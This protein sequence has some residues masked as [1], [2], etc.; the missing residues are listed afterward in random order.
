MQPA[1]SHG[2]GERVSG[3]GGSGGAGGGAGA[4]QATRS[5]PLEEVCLLAGC[6]RACPGPMCWSAGLEVVAWQQLSSSTRGMKVLCKNC[7][8]CARSFCFALL[9]HLED[10]DCKGALSER[11]SAEVHEV[12]VCCDACDACYG[13]AHG[14]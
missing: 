5:M 8:I 9:K 3:G 1:S 6:R 4:A 14:I 12:A 13:N 11:T 2:S 7:C 10:S